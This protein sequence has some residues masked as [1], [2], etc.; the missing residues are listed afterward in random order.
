[1]KL[2][3]SIRR[4]LTLLSRSI[5]FYVEI[6]TAVVFLV[7]LLFVLPEKLDV[8][9]TEYYWFD[10]DA[11]AAAAMEAY[12]F[13]DTGGLAREDITVKVGGGEK[14]A[15]RYTT[16]EKYAVVVDSR[17]DLI[18]LAQSTG[19]AGVAI[20]GPES[21][22]LRFTYYL[23]GYE[24]ARYKSYAALVAGGDLMA[25]AEAAEAQ[26]VRVLEQ[27]TVALNDRQSALPL[28][29][30]LN[31]VLMGILVTAA[32]IVEDKKTNTIKA[33]RV[34]PAPMASY[35]L[36]KVGAVLL[37]SLATCLIIAIP[38]MGG[39]ANYPLL[40]LT[41]LCGGFFTAAVGAL[42]ASFYSDMGKAFAM[43]YLVLLVLLV[44][45]VAGLLPGWDPWWL[46]LIPSYFALQS[47]QDALMD[48][49]ALSVLLSCGGY[50]L[51]GGLVL[52]VAGR[53]Y[54]ATGIGR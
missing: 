35:L 29:L 8:R 42:I 38:V 10:A 20:H 41:V 16:G 53:R 46:R 14:P 49:Q 6:F 11:P 5:Y 36:A 27:N 26:P 54:K 12:Y 23:Q 31:C 24:T 39:A 47:M 37:T 45:A 3:S 52:L 2:L 15:R 9:V 30:T 40:V 34:A 50:L 51:A 43:V 32:Y 4:E 44:P 19:D 18:A 25:V 7:M 1:M 28:M 17:D 13:E 33:L 48:R 22:G 21:D